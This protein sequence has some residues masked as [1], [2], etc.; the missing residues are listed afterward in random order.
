MSKTCSDH[1]KSTICDEVLVRDVMTKDPIT[2]QKFENIIKAAH[3]LADKGISG[4]PVVDKERRVIG[5]VTQAD[6]LAM[7]GMRKEHTFKDFLKHALGEPLLE[8]KTGDIVADIMTTG[9][10]TV[11]PEVSIAKVAQIMDEKKIRRLPV[12]DGEKKLIGIISRADILKAI[13]KK[14]Q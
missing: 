14:L 5:V 3:I 6:I 11:S 8:R 9:V 7:V 13:L 10:V 1:I 4:I 2:V 12:V